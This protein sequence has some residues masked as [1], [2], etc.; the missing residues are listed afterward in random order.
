M[1]LLSLI[2]MTKLYTTAIQ[3]CSGDLKMTNL[4]KAEHLITEACQ[5]T[6]HSAEIPHL[7]CLPE[8]FNFRSSS[9]EEG[10]LA[11]EEIPGGPTFNWACQIAR[12]LNIWLLA[13]SILEKAPGEEKPYNTCFVVNPQGELVAKYRKINLF[14]LQLENAP[15]LCEPKYRQAG[16]KLVS[17]QINDL[18]V[19]LAICFDL[20]FP[21]IF[22][23]YRKQ[24]CELIVLPS[25][26]T[27]K[28]GQA[29]WEILCKARAIEN[30]NFVIAPN[31]STEAN[32]WGHSCI[33]SPWGEVINGL[34]EE[35]EGFVSAELD[36]TE[37]K[38]I[39]E[40]LPITS[41]SSFQS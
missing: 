33:L 8:V 16:K 17:F 27:Y 12:K 5:K 15:E 39:R 6:I 2:I 23:G 10:Y 35:N 25:A 21:E 31:Q 29:H 1:S 40:R 37:V 26:F 3:L 32:C 36:F 4:N 22:A 41:T 18:K 34:D 7:V 11:A 28:T 14:K 38:K 13:G 9:A 30:Q 19:G 20:R 24:G